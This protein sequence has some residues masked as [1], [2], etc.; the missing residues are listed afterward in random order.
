[1][2]FA[3][4]ARQKVRCLH[5]LKVAIQSVQF[6]LLFWRQCTLSFDFTQGAETLTFSLI[7]HIL[8]PVQLSGLKDRKFT[9]T[10]QDGGESLRAVMGGD[11]AKSRLRIVFQRQAVL[12]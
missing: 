9:C 6:R 3:F 4:N 7:P 2:S 1:M 11:K 12:T 5:F 10:L 8:T